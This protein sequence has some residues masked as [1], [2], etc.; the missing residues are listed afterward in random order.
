MG[1]ERF[2]LWP[3]LGS[4]RASSVNN[5]MGKGDILHFDDQNTIRLISELLKSL[6]FEFLDHENPTD[7]ETAGL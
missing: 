7:T 4:F 1:D 6:G 3:V 5:G 2:T